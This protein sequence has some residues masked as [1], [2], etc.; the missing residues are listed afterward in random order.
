MWYPCVRVRCFCVCF[1]VG[2]CI[3]VRLS[4]IPYR[5]HIHSHVR[6]HSSTSSLHRGS[7]PALCM[8][9]RSLHSGP[10]RDLCFV[11][12]SL[13]TTT[14]MFFGRLLMAICLFPAFHACTVLQWVHVCIEVSVFLSVVVTGFQ[15]LGRGRVFIST[16]CFNPFPV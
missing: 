2:V 12:R 15:V 11:A 6:A 10:W 3:R 8:S 4:C 14:I 7:V 13:H 1:C 9:R 16:A 5:L